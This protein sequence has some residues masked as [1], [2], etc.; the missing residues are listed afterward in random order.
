MIQDY[1]VVTEFVNKDTGEKLNRVYPFDAW[2]NN[3]S[4]ELKQVL[5]EV[6]NVL[7][8]F[9]G[10]DRE[11]WSAVTAEAFNKIRRK[12][13]NNINGIARLPSA[14]HCQNISISNVPV[15]EMLARIIDNK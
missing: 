10:K 14:L 1:T 8:Q 3:A 2:C 4:F 5:Y 12:L 11:E 9:E 13:L 7:S 15:S 6:E